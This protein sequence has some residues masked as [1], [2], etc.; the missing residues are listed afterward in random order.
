[1]KTHI[2]IWAGVEC[3][4]NRVGDTFFHQLLKNGHDKRIQDLERFAALGIERIRYPFIWETAAETELAF[5]V[6]SFSLFQA[7]SHAPAPFYNA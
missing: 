7:W 1:M 2:P 4:V 5:A 6:Q 3:T